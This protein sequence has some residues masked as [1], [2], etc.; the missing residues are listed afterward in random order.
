VARGR[1][2]PRR[3][4]FRNPPA[5]PSDHGWRDGRN[6]TIMANPFNFL[7]DVR[8]EAR[9]VTWPSRRETLITTGVVILMVFTTALF[10]LSVDEMIRLVVGFILNLGR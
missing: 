1:K 10:F 4:S 9:K 5:W 3:L 2:V 7:Q 8:A 6:G